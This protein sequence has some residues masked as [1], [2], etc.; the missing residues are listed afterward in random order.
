MIW[1]AH[2]YFLET[3]IF[4]KYPAGFLTVANPVQFPGHM[5][6]LPVFKPGILP[7]SCPTSPSQRWYLHH[8]WRLH[9]PWSCPYTFW[10]QQRPWHKVGEKYPIARHFV[11]KFIFFMYIY[12]YTHIFVFF[13]EC[14]KNKFS[15]NKRTQKLRNNMASRIQVVLHAQ[16]VPLE[17]RP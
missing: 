8:L 7:P 3:P 2:P 9:H 17:E 16:H 4:S 11:F 1:G 10:G 5:A 6:L 14:Y 13:W 15:T 12:I